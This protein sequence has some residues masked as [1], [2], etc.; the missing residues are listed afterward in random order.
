[1]ASFY[2]RLTALPTYRWASLA[3]IAVTLFLPV[4]LVRLGAIEW[5]AVLAALPVALALVVLTFQRLRN[6]NLSGWWII[7]M[8]LTLNFGPRWDGL[9]PIT[10]HLSHL[11]HLIPVAL[12]WLVRAPQA[13]NGAQRD[14]LS[15]VGD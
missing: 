15:P 4:L 1:M 10:L 13:A 3:L 6:A 9:A 8:V 2:H 7:L 12:G 5:V 14:S 11:I